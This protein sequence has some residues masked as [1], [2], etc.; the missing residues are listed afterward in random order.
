MFE[1]LFHVRVCYEC[2]KF[3]SLIVDGRPCPKCGCATEDD[4]FTSYEYHTF[5]RDLRGTTW[6]T[7]RSSERS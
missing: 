3:V 7:M 2:G 5:G 6:E 1:E 4:W